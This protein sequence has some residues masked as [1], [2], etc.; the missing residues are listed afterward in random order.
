[1]TDSAVTRSLSRFVVQSKWRDIPAN[2]R[3]EGKRALLNWLAC[4]LG[5]C[6]DD[7]VE[8]ALR[9]FDAFSGPR[10]ATL[11]GRR[12]Q[13]DPLLAAALNAIASNIL[14]YDD[15]HLPTVIHPS[16]P[17]AAAVF[18]AAA[19]R[20]STGAQLLHAFILG[21]EAE[22]RIGAAVPD[23]YAAGWHITA[24]CGV[25]G[26]AA[27]CGKLIGLSERQMTHAL[28]IAAT[29]AAGLT[30]MLGSMAKCWNMA[31]AARNGY[32]A[33]LLAAQ[34]F[35]SSER[36]LEAPR[37]FAHV[38]SQAPRL[39]EIERDRGRV[40]ALQH[41]AYK[42]FP[43][44]IVLH[45]IIDAC[46]QL[47]AQHAP[48][49]RSV[50]SVTIRS[51]PLALQL[52]G[53]PEPQSGLEGKLSAYHAAAIALI[54]GKAGVAEF[55]DDAVRDPAVLALRRRITA[56]ADDTISTMA[57]QVVI[58]LDDGVRIEKHVEHA[59]GSLEHPLTDEDIEN[60]FHELAASSHSTCH[61]WDAI[62]LA[63]S[64]DQLNDATALV[65]ATMPGHA[66]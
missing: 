54:R 52:A 47:R 38:L 36:A 21:V 62:E 12:E 42:P 10:Q 35:T 57:A 6:R 11:I 32:M 22:C 51:N 45:P 46:I 17:V 27:A 1:M 48:A 7:A 40:W 29:Q 61:A 59:I 44:G 16:V 37:G 39:E 58:E 5:G 55:T 30:E 41:N 15:T 28:G 43:C 26:A 53:K 4:A 49:A 60:K 33:A 18:A 56:H 24:T 65:R 13:V 31:Q 19:H 25:F 20:P 8:R 3:H 66:V 2:I 64:L 23:H 63:W 14:D 50:A 9:A 34:D